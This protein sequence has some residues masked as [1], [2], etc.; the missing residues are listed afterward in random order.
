M[1]LVIVKDNN[2]VTDSLK[3]AEVFG[4][5]HD[6]VLRDIR[7]IGCS[8]EFRLANFGE[9]TYT[10]SQNKEMPMYYMNRKAFTLLVMGYTGKEAMRYK[11]A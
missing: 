3:I 7:G 10:N 8:E 9:S 5:S 4:K 11:E 6:K 1:N 2:A